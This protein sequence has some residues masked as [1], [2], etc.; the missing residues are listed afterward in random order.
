M[1]ILAKGTEMTLSTPILKPI[2]NASQALPETLYYASRLASGGH[3]PIYKRLMPDG[4]PIE[5]SP[6]PSQE[7]YNHSPDGFQWG[8]GGSGPA[9]L[10]LA[11]LLDAT[12]DR[13][14]SLAFYQAFKWERVAT[15][16]DSWSI[17]RGFILMWV[18]GQQDQQP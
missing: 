11:L 2:E 17:T 15:W 8:Y 5:L 6:E 18:K 4:D 14:T 16:G 12:N 7:L 10:A 1:E 3:Q 13:E 9:Q